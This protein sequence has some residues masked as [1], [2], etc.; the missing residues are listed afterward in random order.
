MTRLH[1]VILRSGPAHVTCAF[2]VAVVLV[3]AGCQIN[4]DDFD[5]R[6]QINTGDIGDNRSSG[7]EPP[8]DGR[9]GGSCRS[10]GSCDDD[11]LCLSNLCVAPPENTDDDEGSGRD[12]DGKDPDDSE[13]ER[14]EHGDDDADGGEGDDGG[15]G[16]SD[17]QDDD[18]GSDGEGEW[19]GGE[20][21]GE[22]EGSG[23]ASECEWSTVFDAPLDVIPAGSFVNCSPSGDCRTEMM[24]G[25]TALVGGSDWNQV[26]SPEVLPLNARAAFV[27]VDVYLPSED[28]SATLGLHNQGAGYNDIFGGAVVTF[29]CSGD[30]AFVSVSRMAAEHTNTICCSTTAP[31]EELLHE[32]RVA[33]GCD[34][35]LQRWSH[36]RLEASN[37]SG[38][39]RLLVNGEEWAQVFTGPYD[40]AQQ[41]VL[42]GANGPSWSQANVAYTDVTIGTGTGSNCALQ[43]GTTGG[44]MNPD[45]EGTNPCGDACAP[46]AEPAVRTVGDAWHITN[47]T[48]VQGSSTITLDEIPALQAGDVVLVHQTQ[49]PSSAGTY[50]FAMVQAV[51]GTQVVLNQPLTHTYESAVSP[52]GRS[53]QL[54]KVLH[55]DD[56]LIPTDEEWR[57]RTWDGRRGGVLALDAT[58]EVRVFGRINVDGAGF[59]GGAPG[60]NGAGCSYPWPTMAGEPGESS[61]GPSTLA[62]PCSRQA[63]LIGHLVPTSPNGGGGGGGAGSTSY[64]FYLRSGG[65]GGGGGHLNAGTAGGGSTNNPAGERGGLGGSALGLAEQSPLLVL[66][67]GGGGGGR[68]VNAYGGWGGH[69][70]GAVIIRAGSIGGLGSISA[71]G[72]PGDPGLISDDGSGGGGGG[73]G[74]T[75]ILE[76]A[77]RTTTGASFARAE[78]GA[79]G[80]RG[81]ATESAAIFGHP[82]Y[83][84]GGSGGAGSR[85]RVVVL[86]PVRREVGPWGPCIST[87]MCGLTGLWSR[88]VQERDCSQGACDVRLLNDETATCVPRTIAEKCDD[89]DPSNGEDACNGFGEC[90]SAPWQSAASCTVQPSLG[91]RCPE[92]MTLIPSGSFLMGRYG[93]MN[94]ERPARWTAV[95]AFCIDNDE[96]TVSDVTAGLPDADVWQTAA[97]GPPKLL[98]DDALQF[99]RTRGAAL[100]TEAQWEFAARGCAGRASGPSAFGLAGMEAGGTE[101]VADP[102]GAY[103]ASSWLNPGGALIGHYR[104]ARGHNLLTVRHVSGPMDPG[105]LLTESRPRH[106]VRC[107]AP[108]LVPDRPLCGNGIVDTGEECDDGN[109]IDGDGCT[110]VCD[111]AR[112]GD[113]VQQSD[114][115]CDDGN[116]DEA[117]ACTSSCA[118]ARCGDGKVRAGVEQ[119]DDGNSNNVDACSNFC[120]YTAASPFSVRDNGQTVYDSRSGLTWA[121]SPSVIR[122]NYQASITYCSQFQVNGS[123]G[124]RVPNVAELR[125]LIDTRFDPAIDPNAFPATSTDLFWSSTLGP[126]IDTRMF[127]G[128]GFGSSSAAS[129]DGSLYLVRCVRDGGGGGG[130]G[131][132]EGEGEG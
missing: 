78:G 70:G 119:C 131:E 126:Y 103:D 107:V 111:R 38:S 55:S 121:R 27:D 96:A 62:A 48:V 49:H 10:D 83:G 79:G 77:E 35:I 19:D 125:A 69:G 51:G 59:R 26:L 97:N 7:R 120:A 87:E 17:E 74:G 47:T 102:Y 95:S 113:G 129:W 60:I 128:F 109:A 127:V 101:W 124:W 130:G 3:G 44:N 86:A 93:G 23:S 67:A 16:G 105:Q 12:D 33:A 18:D 98:F 4:I 89:G 104:V 6:G 81:S 25:R 123:A 29:G 72:L 68:G 91:S 34:S 57:P 53:A 92:G 84:T 20:G 32:H 85:G 115:Q 37:E 42:L 15:G 28:R 63:N 94:I 65:G 46:V 82:D 64:N 116:T 9:E 76:A 8:A 21:E 112:C 90:H 13:G 31:F 5:G 36:V 41:R 61:L 108:V 39:I 24:Y 30:D 114:E 22:G 40:A 56:L 2:S 71:S 122:I 1:P 106:G 52:V 100:P 54:V 88:S 43:D 14:G 66:G 132:G 80:E 58:G 73:A 110:T 118:W 99:C 45:D 50:E 75:I 117:D 11:L